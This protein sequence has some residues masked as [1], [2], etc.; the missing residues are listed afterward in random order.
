[1]A[2]LAVKIENEASVLM[3]EFYDYNGWCYALSRSRTDTGNQCIQLEDFYECS[4][5]TQWIDHIPVIFVADQQ[6]IGWYTKACIYEKLQIVSTFLE[7]NIKAAIGDAILLPASSRK[8]YNQFNFGD[9]FYEVI[10]DDDSR[11]EQL[12]TILSSNAKG[13][14]IRYSQVES[15]YK[16][17]NIRLIGIKHGKNLKEAKKAQEAYCIQQ[18]GVIAQAVMADACKDI[19]ELKTM[20]QYADQALVYNR[21][22]VDGWYYKAMACEQLGMNKEGL[23][24]IE[25]AIS[26]EEDGDDLICQKGHLL[27]AL[28]QYD[29]AISCYE[30]AYNIS[31]EQGYLLYLGRAWSTKGNMDQA[32]KAYSRIENKQLLEDS[33]INLKDMEKRWPFVLA[34]GFSFKDLFSKKR[35]KKE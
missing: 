28:G 15:L 18:C 22:S 35:D 20:Y 17:D 23:K 34:R 33:G 30:E 29:Q 7:G 9:K 27:F 8:T 12:E 10:E 16:G 25:K 11:Y 26:Q 3:N 6:I 19:R 24:A 14:P 31:G 5:Q 21:Q 2:I 4:L 13:L 32:Y 1:M